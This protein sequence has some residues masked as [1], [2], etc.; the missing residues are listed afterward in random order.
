MYLLKSIT[1][2]LTFQESFVKFFICS[3]I[4]KFGEGITYHSTSYLLRIS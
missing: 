2:L 1:V 4:Y 3:G